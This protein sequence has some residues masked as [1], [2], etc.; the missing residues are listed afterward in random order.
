MTEKVGP[1]Q[2]VAIGYQGILGDEEFEAKKRQILEV[3]RVRR[4]RLHH[5]TRGVYS[6][7]WRFLPFIFLAPS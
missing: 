4:V 6:R 5:Q 3:R 1:V 7:R 2:L